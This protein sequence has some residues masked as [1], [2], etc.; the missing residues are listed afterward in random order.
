MERRS[1][2]P[3]ASAVSPIG[4]GAMP[5]S[6]QGRP[7][8]AQGIRV[9]HAVLDAGVTFV[10][11]A[12][13]YCLDDRDIGHNEQLI[14]QALKTWSG[15]RDAALIATKG[16]LTRPKGRW[17][18]DAR[19]D[20]L[21]DACEQSLRALEVDCIDLYQ[22]H[23]PDPN[24]PFVDS[25]GVLADLQ[26]QG[27]IRW[28]GLSNVS[29]D[30]IKEAQAVANVVSVQNRLNLFF[31]EALSDGV[32]NYCRDHGMAF[33]AYSPLGGS[34]F[35]KNLSDHAVLRSIAECHRRSPYAVVLNWLL[36]QAPNI[37]PIPGARTVDHALDSVSDAD[38]PLDD[39][40]LEAITEAGF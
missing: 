20:K 36:A 37:I 34:Q 6:I 35:N 31:R 27:K 14:V 4:F 40:E 13:V 5:L 19:P 1:L 21:K 39:E 9:I 30:E 11:T 22:L 12:N 23:A 26:N 2:G 33:I 8:E 28:I 3:G 25:V 32:V 24:V 17:E 18:S 29:V 10:D 38:L 7:D 15:S 16:G